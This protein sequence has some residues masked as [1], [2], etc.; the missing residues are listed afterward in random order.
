MRRI[1]GHDSFR[2]DPDFEYPALRQ[3]KP[4]S[5][6]TVT[7]ISIRGCAHTPSIEISESRWRR[8]AWREPM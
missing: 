1:H 8:A 4:Q 7:K 3:A 5:V 6:I 2:I